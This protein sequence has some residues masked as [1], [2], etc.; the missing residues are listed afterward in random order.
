MLPTESTFP[1]F[2]NNQLLTA[3]DLNQLFGYLDGQNKLTRINLLGIGIVCGLQVKVNPTFTEIT[4]GRGCGV[5]SEGYLITHEETVYTQRKLYAVDTEIIYDRFL[6][7]DGINE[8]K[9]VEVW[10]LIQEGTEEDTFLI[11][12]AFLENKVILLFVELKHIKNKNCDP[13]NCD[14]KGEHITVSFLPMAVSKQ[15][16]AKY[17]LGTTAGVFGKSTYTSLQELRMPRWDVPNTRPVATKDILKA[18]LDVL[19]KGFIGQVGDALAKVYENFPLFFQPDF[20]SNPFSGFSE[21]FHFLTEANLDG[22]QL[23]HL[24]YY[25]DL[26]SD[27]LHTYQEVRIAGTRILGM[28]CPDHTLFPRHLLL[29]EAIPQTTEGALAYRHYFIH[30]PLFDQGNTLFEIKSLFKK[31]VLLVEHFFLPAV[32]G[33]NQKTDRFLRITPSVLGGVPLS[34]KAIPYYYHVN[35]GPKPLYLHWD[36][37]RTQL[38]DAQNQLSYHADKYHSGPPEGFVLSPLNYDL[39]PYNFLRVE[40][41]VGKHYIHVLSQIKQHI[42]SRRLPVDVIALSTDDALQWD[43]NLLHRVAASKDA[44]DMICHFQDLESM[45]DSIRRELLCT[46]CKELRYYYDFF[47]GGIASVYK[48]IQTANAVSAVS[49]FDAC[50]KGYTVRVQTFGVI[51]EHLHNLGITDETLNFVNFF[52]AFG[53]N[54]A[55]ED[56]DNIPDQFKGQLPAI[57]IIALNLFKLPLGIIRLSTLLTED[58]SDFD[59]K[60]YCA[61][62]EAVAGYAQSLKSLFSMFT[63]APSATA[64]KADEQILDP[65]EDKV[66]REAG[67]GV[68]NNEISN[69]ETRKSLS[70]ENTSTRALQALSASNN[71]L[72]RLVVLLLVIEDFLDHLDVLIYNCK[73]SALLSLKRDYLVRYR[74]VAR[75]RQFGYFT[76]MHPGIQHKAGVPMGGTFILVYHA[77]RQRVASVRETFEI[78]DERITANRRETLRRVSGE[79]VLFEKED[80]QSFTTK[81]TLIAGRI[82]DETGTPLIGVKLM[83]EETGQGVISNADGFF[84]IT[85][86]VLP[87]TVV[88]KMPGY[89][90]FSRK[91]TGP[92]DGLLITLQPLADEQGEIFTEGIV[93]ADFYLPYRCCSECPPVQFIVQDRQPDEKP[94]IGPKANAGQDQ[95]IELPNDIVTLNGSGSTDPDGVIV[96]YKWQMLSGPGKPKIVSDKSA[97]TFVKGL[98][99]G[100]YEFELTV[101]DDKG[102]ID[103]DSVLVKVLP[104]PPPPNTPPKADAGEDQ[105]LLMTGQQP[106]S[107]ML[108]GS[109]STDKEG[110]IVAFKWQ[111]TEGAAKAIISFPDNSITLVTL[112]QPD[113]YGFKLTVTDAGGLQ[114]SDDVTIM[115]ERAPNQPPV[116]KPEVAGGNT[117]VLN[118]NTT[119]SATL[120]GSNS[121]DPEGGA[122]TFNWSLKAFPQGGNPPV[123]TNS[124]APNTS[125]S[126]LR[127]GET[128]FNLKVTDP[129]GESGDADVTIRVVRGENKPPTANAGLNRTLQF[130]GN[131]ITV[132][133]DG[134]SSSDPEN[135][136]LVY[137]WKFIGSS[138]LSPNITD[139][140]TAITQAT[141]SAPGQ[142]PFEL[143]VTDQG[144]LSDVAQVV[145][146][147]EKGE[148]NQEKTLCGPLSDIVKAFESFDERVRRGGVF[149][150]FAE[151]YAFY[152]PITEYFKA[153]AKLKDGDYAG[154]FKFFAKAFNQRTINEWLF[155]WLTELQ[156]I[157]ETNRELRQPALGLYEILVQ[158]TLYIACIQKEDLKQQKLPLADVL[159]L[160]KAH[161]EVWVKAIDS[162]D[163]SATHQ[164][165]VKL[166]VDLLQKEIAKIDSDG[167]SN[168]KPAYRDAL[169]RILNA[170]S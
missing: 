149:A 141:L 59:A 54:P 169:V 71:G 20:T 158:L 143:R 65:K 126:G 38:N 144:G 104:A 128:T 105:Q 159:E 50:A 19:N 83:I 30:S 95:E 86:Q 14:D 79:E 156:K 155:L 89:E 66:V 116:A 26:F 125:V 118:A 124:N 68:P 33:N 81:P 154:H 94:N 27:L 11:D 170:L 164:K 122:L 129:E 102:A 147:V 13:Q 111:Q 134:S 93:F 78:R 145:I 3:G 47:I 55:D 75:L 8:P 106:V 96:S 58:L 135:L 23:L 62:A 165:A 92:D 133:L 142:Y 100:I 148:I 99:D 123:I 120:L 162:G 6:I 29:G 2:V 36:L 1:N 46:L 91:I 163:F 37:H 121:F 31:L 115:V 73:C 48:N 119:A 97:E 130:S 44:G 114:N 113:K 98:E 9:P 132:T 63:G 88:V 157:I 64:F 53:F 51:I 45:Y 109:K 166:I 4:I 72:L 41:I 110:P 80:K 61:A 107:A 35:S 60:K 34:K 25:Y 5:T 85:S 146:T 70:V 112:P 40:G 39:E 139:P 21:K 136:P 137:E 76:S 57:F 32:Q 87:F 43:S 10:E 84:R 24:Q 140:R 138:S 160:I 7:P 90:I 131:S 18:Y 52:Q 67:T 151:S 22:N 49:L 117:I 15:D 17:L 108:D 152:G 101:T 161:A 153:L 56:E 82:E 69:I 16:A 77:Q 42:R 127:F 28:C 167:T 74:Q 12:K 103:R 150:Q 168:S